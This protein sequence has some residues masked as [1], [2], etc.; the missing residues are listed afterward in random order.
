MAGA[1]NRL[2]APDGGVGFL[3]REGFKIGGLGG[4]SGCFGTE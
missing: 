1:I 2:F 3:C 4:W